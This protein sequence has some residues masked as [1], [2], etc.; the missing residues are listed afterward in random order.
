MSIDDSGVQ[1]TEPDG[2]VYMAT[3]F[4]PQ[5]WYGYDV[6]NGMLIC[7]MM[8]TAYDYK[9]DKYYTVNSGGKTDEDRRNGKNILRAQ[10]ENLRDKYSADDAGERFIAK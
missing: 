2:S 9:N 4:E 1:I 6:V 7:Q 5:E 3:E 8:G 10:A